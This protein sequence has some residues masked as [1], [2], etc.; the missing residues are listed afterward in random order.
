MK[1][2]R[3]GTGLIAVQCFTC[4]VGL[5]PVSSST[6]LRKIGPDRRLYTTDETK[7]VTKRHDR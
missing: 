7:C 1:D 2:H 5:L 6:P 3:P 4:A